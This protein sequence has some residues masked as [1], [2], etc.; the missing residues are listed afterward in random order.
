MEWN[1]EKIKECLEVLRELPDFDHLLLPDEWAKEF[2]IPITP[3]KVYDLDEYMRTH[4][5]SRILGSTNQSETREPDDKGI[6]EVPTELPLTLEVTTKIVDENSES[7]NQESEHHHQA[8]E[9]NETMHLENPVDSSSHL[10]D[11]E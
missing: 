3:A 6:R 1:R 10:H 4:K 5:M 8:I 9:S 11:V 2:D 7:Q